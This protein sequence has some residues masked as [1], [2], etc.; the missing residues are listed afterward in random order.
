MPTARIPLASSIESRSASLGKDSR[1]VNGL[2]ES[3]GNER[4]V[5][6]RPGLIPLSITP[7][8]AAGIGQGIFSWNNYLLAAVNNTLYLITGQNSAAVLGTVV[9][10][11]SV[12]F[13]FTSVANDVK[14]ALHNGANLYTVSA[15]SPPTFIG[16]VGLTGVV[17]SVYISAG[18]GYYGLAT[19][20]TI[21][22]GTPPTITLSSHGLV[23]GQGV[24]FTA[25]VMPTGLVAGTTYQVAS[26]TLNTFTINTCTDAGG[27]GTAVAVTTSGTAVNVL[28]SPTVTFGVSPGTTALG[29]VTLYNHQ[30][31]GVIVTTHGAGYLL[32]PVITFSAPIA[33]RQATGT[34]V[35]KV[36]TNAGGNAVLAVTSVTITDAGA[37]YLA[38]PTVTFT[39][40][41]PSDPYIGGRVAW[42]ATGTTTVA[43]NT[44]VLSINP[45]IGAYGVSGQYYPDPAYYPPS[46][47]I[48]CT[49]SAPTSDGITATGTVTM[50][51]GGITGPFAPGIA[52]LDNKVYVMGLDGKVYDS[53]TNDPS[54]WAGTYL[55]A[56]SDPD[57]GVG[58]V[59]H[60][61]YLLCFGQ[62]ST[63]AFYDAGNPTG[64]P[65]AVAQT[66]KM[67]IGCA[68]GNSIAASEQTV[69]WVGQALTQG[70][71]VYL[72]DGMSPQKVSSRYI[73]KYLNAD[74]ML[75]LRSYCYKVA[76]HSLYVLTLHDQN[77]TFV[78][79]L[80]EKEWYQW[81]SQS[82]DT[83]IVNSG[84][85]TYYTPAFYSGNVEY[86]AA[87]Y[88][89]D[90]DSGTIYK[91]DQSYTTD[92]GRL[93]YLRSI[94][95]ILDS[96]STKRKFYRKIEVVADKIN[97]VDGTSQLGYIRSSDDDYATTSTFRSVDL[98]V[99]RPQLYQLGSARRR[100]W[101][102]FHSGATPLR[103]DGLE[104]DFD[105]GEM[106][107]V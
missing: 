94:T 9:G 19:P 5:V 79:D 99:G 35:T 12:P 87:P 91:Q 72:M 85:E 34:P 31:S 40:V 21:A 106:E 78:Y 70:R 55:Q 3:K 66:Y 56:S 65:L 95:P 30:V 46:N 15:G 41:N 69:L 49:L 22:T 63:E 74:A 60:L 88:L 76:G 75:N 10:S 61:N 7:A 43:N 71:S 2:I 20:V 39:P 42:A 29:T 93:I 86:Q 103:I 98:S 8:I 54:S 4:Q 92:A 73:D 80:D 24:Q 16:G 68:N 77:I 23:V 51:S 50:A 14:L 96:G 89:L 13:S 82:G 62:W 1:L 53:A 25:T 28:A 104:V 27:V 18:G 33:R 59:R 105:I 107:N 64:S 17:S 36:Y 38:A 81:T 52:Y 26:A 101:E 37:G 83:G 44:A 45:N 97:S 84:T 32:A 6:K 47:T 67:E 11:T 100:S 48:L 58:L 57:N 90:D 102:F